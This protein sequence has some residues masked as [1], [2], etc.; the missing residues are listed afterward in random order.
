MASLEKENI[1]F[2]PAALETG[3]L[4]RIETDPV[5]RSQAKAE[6]L[7][8]GSVFTNIASRWDAEMSCHF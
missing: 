8:N 7:A 4:F 1:D 3:S 5:R 6:S 2:F